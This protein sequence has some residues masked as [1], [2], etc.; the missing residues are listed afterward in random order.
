MLFVL[1]LITNYS[2]FAQKMQLGM[3]EK[4]SY[5]PLYNLSVKVICDRQIDD[6]T[7]GTKDVD[8]L[9]AARV[10]VGYTITDLLILQ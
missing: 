1:F 6:V 9:R 10:W 4:I 7:S 5:L 8:L 2:N 3:V